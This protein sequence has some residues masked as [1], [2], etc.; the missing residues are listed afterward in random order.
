MDERRQPL[1]PHDT[2]NRI[3]ADTAPVA[4]DVGAAEGDEKRAV[5]SGEIE[6]VP[7]EAP[8]ENSQMVFCGDEQQVREGFAVALRAKGPDADFLPVGIPFYQP[9]QGG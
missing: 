2:C 5:P 9:K 4:L 7:A 3:G 6:P 8:P 1:P